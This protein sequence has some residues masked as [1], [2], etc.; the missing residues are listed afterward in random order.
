MIY[1]IHGK[2]KSIFIHNMFDLNDDTIGYFNNYLDIGK[3]LEMLVDTSSD[4]FSF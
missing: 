3:P 2:L 4:Q 1:E